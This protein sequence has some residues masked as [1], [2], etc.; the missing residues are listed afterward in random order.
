MRA[1]PGFGE[2]EE[3]CRRSGGR[4]TS[5]RRGVLV[6]VATAERPLTA[7]EILDRIRD[8]HG[9]VSPMS[10]YRSL[11]FLVAQAIVHRIESTKTFVACT[12]PGQH[13]PTQ[14]LVCRGCGAVVETADA[15]LAEVAAELGRRFR[16]QV[17]RSTIELI[18][19]CAGCQQ[20]G[21]P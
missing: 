18:G 14:V 7:Y 20:A 12:L 4:W 3:I 21:Q 1:N 8:R 17:D 2:L 6:T 13:H 11:D 5:R 9:D 16:F 10:I 15:H 19:L